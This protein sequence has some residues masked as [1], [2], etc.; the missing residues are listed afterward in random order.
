MSRKKRNIEVLSVKL[1]FADEEPRTV[2][3]AD[4]LNCLN[5]RKYRFQEKIFDFSLLPTDKLNCIV[6]I[7]I[8]TQDS[9]IPPKRNKLTGVY[10]T[11]QI[12]VQTEGFAY[13]NIFLYDTDRNIL[14]YEINKNGCFPNQLKEFI[15]SSWNADEDNVH[16]DISFPS[17]LRSHEYDRMLRMDRYK[18]I[19]V[20]LF[21]PVEL[22]DDIRESTDSI[23]NNILKS[24]INFGAQTN[25]STIVIEQTAFQKR[26]N[27]DGLSR[28]KVKGLV[29]AV[30]QYINQHNIQTLTVEGYDSDS[31]DPKRCKVIDLVG[32]T[33]N[34]YFWITDVQIHSDV[35][36]SERKEGIET[37]Y[38][39]L[40][41]EFRQ[42][43]GF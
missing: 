18:K 6:G 26:I 38:E 30:L 34:E 35:Q 5:G 43:I 32:D 40:L 20:E 36:Q 28:S 14:L 22:V 24:N 1:R 29:D 15:Y 21:N 11:I 16:F 7:I 4:I 42:I 9:D 33:F 41:P 27:M 39:R 8:T 19:K 17:V 3:F 31:E 12:D 13:A 37:L 10:N 23:Y 25:A 2:T